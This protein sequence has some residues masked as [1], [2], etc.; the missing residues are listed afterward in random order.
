VDALLACVVA[1]FCDPHVRGVGL[2]GHRMSQQM[3]ECQRDTQAQTLPGCAAHSAITL[4]A[5]ECGLVL[6]VKS[7]VHSW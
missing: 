2:G 5:S 6:Y 1:S 3:H 4:F 7:M